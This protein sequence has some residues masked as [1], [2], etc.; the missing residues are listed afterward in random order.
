MTEFSA[1]PTSAFQRFLNLLKLCGAFFVSFVA[2]SV[3]I[4]ATRSATN[5]GAALPEKK[6][7]F[8][9]RAPIYTD[10]TSN[11][12]SLDTSG[13]LTENRVKMAGI[14]ESPKAFNEV[15]KSNTNLP[16]FVCYADCYH[17]KTFDSREVRLIRESLTGSGVTKEGAFQALKANCLNITYFELEKEARLE[18]KEMGFIYVA[19][20]NNRSSHTQATLVND[21]SR[22]L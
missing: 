9:L 10:L 12:K 17:K 2:T 8:G 5:A 3:L 4:Y 6:N 13:G 22:N 16:G 15:P 19:L 7:H 20:R 14:L 21:C 11:A 18:K 1:L